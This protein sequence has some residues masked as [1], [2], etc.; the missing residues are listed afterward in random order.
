LELHWEIH[1]RK[2]EEKQ[3]P[4]EKIVREK[5]TEFRATSKP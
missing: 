5:P 3:N 1:W 4:E 2:K